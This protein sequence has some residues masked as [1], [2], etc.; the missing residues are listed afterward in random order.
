L[1]RAGAD[2]RRDGIAQIIVI[3]PRAAV[4]R[5]QDSRRF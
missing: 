4:Q 2:D 3:G 5:Q 1:A